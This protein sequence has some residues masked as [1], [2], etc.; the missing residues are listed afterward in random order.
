VHRRFSPR[1]PFSLTARSRGA[2]R[3]AH[4]FGPQAHAPM[5]RIKPPIGFCTEIQ[6]RKAL[7]RA[8]ARKSSASS[9]TAR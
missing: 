3:R 5:R 8:E 9:K 1:R 6:T 7:N 2:G 4:G